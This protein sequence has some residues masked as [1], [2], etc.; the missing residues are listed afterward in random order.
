MPCSWHHYPNPYWMGS[1]TFAQGVTPSHKKRFH[2][3]VFSTSVDNSRTPRQSMHLS[4][5]K[6]AFAVH[7]VTF[8]SG[9]LSLAAWP[10]GCFTFEICD[11]LSGYDFGSSGQYVRFPHDSFYCLGWKDYFAAKIQQ[12]LF[13]EGQFGGDS[14]GVDPVLP[15]LTV[16][17]TDT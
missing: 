5:R 16:V 17:P 7:V 2:S 11:Y 15:C 1:H 9:H 14:L 10:D 3:G 8:F 12:V 13:V 4:W 6:I